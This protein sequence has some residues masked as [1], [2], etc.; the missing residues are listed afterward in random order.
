ME[1]KPCPTRIWYDAGAAFTIGLIGGSLWNTAKGFRNAPKGSKTL[2]VIKGGIKAGTTSASNFGSWGLAFSTT[3][4]IL[5]E[6]RGTEDI[7]N[8]IIAGGVAGALLSFREGYLKMIQGG[9]IGALL[10]G[11]IE[12]VNIGIMKVVEK[13]QNGGEGPSA[14]QSPTPNTPTP[15]SGGSSE[16]SSYNQEIRQ[17]SQ[18]EIY[19]NTNGVM[20]KKVEQNQYRSFHNFLQYVPILNTS[21]QYYQN[22][23]NI[24]N[25]HIKDIKFSYNNLTHTI[26]QFFTK[27]SSFDTIDYIKF[28][29]FSNNNNNNIFNQNFNTM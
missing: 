11:L 28:Q 12:G 6:F 16:G 20:A 18:L 27:K 21:K 17:T 7:W 23:Y 13:N 2:N 1:I 10:L 22:S 25:S 8:P 29:L 5:S 26:N 24:I 19:F 15:N 9:F 3:E 4:C 14:P